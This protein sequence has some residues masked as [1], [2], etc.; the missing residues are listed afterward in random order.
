LWVSLIVA[1][2]L[3]IIRLLNWQRGTE[4]AKRF[5]GAAG[6]APD[7]SSAGALLATHES[8]APESAPNQEL[9]IHVE[10]AIENFNLQVEF[11]TGRGAVG[12]LGASGAGKSMTLRMIA[13]VVAPDRGR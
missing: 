6:T 13:G 9:E 2:S 10:K 12:L 7:S 5:A 11:R 1:L 4:T 3:A 8:R